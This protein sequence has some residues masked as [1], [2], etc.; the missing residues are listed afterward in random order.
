MHGE[1]GTGKSTLA[2]AVGRATGAVVLDKDYIKGPLAAGGI[3]DSLA[4]GL[5][6]DIFWLLAAS[7]L[8]QGFDVVL[9]SPVF[10]PRIAERGR[11]LAA[12][13]GAGY[14]V[15]EC[16]CDDNAEQERRLTS[17]SRQASQPGSRAELAVA[18]ARPGVV[19]ALSEPHLR[20][21]TTRSLEECLAQ[22]LGYIGHDAS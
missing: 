9:D 17:R 16:R 20:V 22:V 21:D 14:F 4:G 2:L 10:W 8:E 11:A 7:M 15:V 1:S 12:A 13:A 18:L 3:E 6:Y 19:R 5:A